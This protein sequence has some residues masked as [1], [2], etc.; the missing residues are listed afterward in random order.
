MPFIFEKDLCYVRTTYYSE[1]EDDR[2]KTIRPP[3]QMITYR[4]EPDD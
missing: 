4:G 2:A 3:G 1:M